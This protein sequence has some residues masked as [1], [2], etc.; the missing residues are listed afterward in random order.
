[1]TLVVSNII[2]WHSLATHRVK[3]IQGLRQ[4][5]DRTGAHF[6]ILGG[7]LQLEGSAPLLQKR[8][9]PMILCIKIGNGHY[10][11]AQLAILAFLKK[12]ATL[13][14][15]KIFLRMGAWHP[16]ADLSG[17][18]GTRGTRAAAAHGTI[19]IYS[20]LQIARLRILF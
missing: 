10:L 14:A 19:I 2:T 1:M 8:K 9:I 7:G 12:M 18:L 4:G 11:H 13:L 3:H 15:P 16:L 20:I 17:C 5:F 6:K